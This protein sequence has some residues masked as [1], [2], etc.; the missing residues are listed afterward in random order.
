MILPR[1][2][3]PKAIYIYCDHFIPSNKS[4][5][6]RNITVLLLVPKNATQKMS[7]ITC[8]S[9]F[10]IKAIYYTSHIHILYGT[11]KEQ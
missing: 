11:E 1:Y 3:F 8:F 2:H 10:V 9:T 5:F 4:S 7:K 6:I